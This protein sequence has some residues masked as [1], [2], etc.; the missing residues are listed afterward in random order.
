MS[1]SST[2]GLFGVDLSGI[3][4]AF[5]G[6]VFDRRFHLNFK[7]TNRKRIQRK[8]LHSRRC[9]C[10]ARHDS[11]GNASLLPIC[12]EQLNINNNTL[13]TVVTKVSHSTD[14]TFLYFLNFCITKKV[15]IASDFYLRMF[16]IWP[17]G[18]T[19]KTRMGLLKFAQV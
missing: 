19:F 15:H 9:L 2:V 13:S 6:F 17:I 18:Y 12:N 8:S 16:M 1:Q 10:P 5:I 7:R 14:S 4:L 3:R 11:M